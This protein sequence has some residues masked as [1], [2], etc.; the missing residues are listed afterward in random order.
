MVA[1]KMACA[2]EMTLAPT[3]RDLFFAL[4]LLAHCAALLLLARMST[5]LDV[6]LHPPKPGP[7]QIQWVRLEP[8]APLPSAV[9]EVAPKPLPMRPHPKPRVRPVPPPAPVPV[10]PVRMP[11]P[12]AL[13]AEV[14]AE[15]APD[16]QADGQNQADAPH[17]VPEAAASGGAPASGNAEAAPEVT[18][19]RYE[20]DYLSNPAPEYPALSQSLGE[21][22][23]VMLRVHITA[24]GRADQVLLQQGSGFLRLD[25]AAREVIWRWRFIPARRGTENVPGWV[26]VPIRFNLRK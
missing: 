14:P 9:P 6:P 15:E 3:L 16:G 12:E 17:D 18:P 10:T 1:P 19:P 5:V 4:V 26:V 11:E 22:G 23:L 2:P 21:Q 7:L 8:P 24:D 13:R 25:R 20:A